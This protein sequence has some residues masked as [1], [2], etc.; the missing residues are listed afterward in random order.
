[1]ALLPYL[2]P[3]SEGI[4]LLCQIQPR[5]SRTEIVGPHGDPPRLKIRITAPPVDGEANAELIAFLSK[6]LKIPKHRFEIAGGQSSKLK[7]ILVR[8]ATPAELE[9]LGADKT[10]PGTSGR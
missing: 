7:R 10:R 1:L 9:A 4:T 6:K 2:I 8:G 5:A 3:S